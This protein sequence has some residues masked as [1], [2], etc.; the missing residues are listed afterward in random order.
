[1]PAPGVSAVTTS[2]LRQP[3]PA[4]SPGSAVR[5]PR[6]PLRTTA[7]LALAAVLSQA[8]C[9]PPPAAPPPPPPHGAEAGPRATA[10][11][12]L[13]RPWIR[14][15]QGAR[16]L[17][18]GAQIDALNRANAAARPA[19][20]QDVTSRALAQPRRVEAERAERRAWLRDRVRRG[21]YVEGR[22]DALET[23]LTTAAGA[24]AVDELRVLVRD[25]DLRCV[26]T[27]AGLY[28]PAR[29]LAF[30]RNQC[31][32]VRAATLTRVLARTPG[33][34]WW[35]VHAGHSVGWI[36]RPL[37]TPPVSAAAAR[38]YRNRKPRVFVTRPRVTVSPG[39]TLRMGASLPLAG[40]GTGGG[41]RTARV[42]TVLVPTDGGLRPRRVR[43]GHGLA[44]GPLPFTRRAVY[45]LALSLLGEP[46]GWG[47]RAGGLDCSR[48]TLDVFAPFGL[49]LGRHSGEQGLEGS[50]TIELAGLD[51]AARRSA[52][53][54]ALARGIV[55]A[56]MPG[57]VFLVLGRDGA[58]HY[59][60]S[61]VSEIY[62]PPRRASG[63]HGPP[64]DRVR[65]PDRVVVTDLA[66]GA[67]SS[68]G[69]Y[70]SRL[71]R[72]AVFGKARPRAA[73]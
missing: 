36:E 12:W 37:A 63:S 67:G 8:A 16:P 10:S 52:L 11:W 48:L 47:E 56:T 2:P 6:G 70:L 46:Y 34:R 54:R 71:D 20:A 72:L 51:A 26:P 39:L 44:L 40:A 55:L 31:G 7:A 53:D 28:T 69:A 35:Y 32:R 66:V 30:D 57:H 50:E 64:T 5:R 25:A 1:M 49:R 22:P 62:L 4:P 45:D 42:W 21:V 13:A 9:A 60:L 18:T 73:P 61:A 65:R 17:L 14:G 33:G 58:H 43:L 41:P 59:A 24:E 68:R 29:D 19:A 38:R 27:G 23:A 15:K 3:R